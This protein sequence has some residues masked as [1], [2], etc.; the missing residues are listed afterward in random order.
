L[1]SDSGSGR[2]RE[3]V[4]ELGG[5]A[6]PSNVA[7]ARGAELVFL[8]HKPRQ[9]D[10]VA[11]EIAGE[12]KAVASVLGGIPIA[13]L[14]RAYPGAS[15][16][17]VMPNTP[18]E[19]RQGVICYSPA[20]DVD[21]G[22]DAELVALLERL[23]SVVRIEERLM[24]AAT[25]VMGVGPAYLA[26]VVEAQVDAAVRHGLKPALASRLAAETMSGTASLLE[27]RDYNTLTLRR[28]VAS[29]GGTTARGLAA[30]DRAGLRAAFQDA[31]DAVVAGDPR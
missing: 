25:S 22:L 7:V 8:C 31:T 6:A 27:A 11:R 19:V 9:L 26:V 16:F 1:C 14:Q 28:E 4:A 10:E 23:G 12:V 30:F 20:D 5:E 2:A 24:S 18:V 17:R 29:P 21:Q 13:E 3:L 15:V